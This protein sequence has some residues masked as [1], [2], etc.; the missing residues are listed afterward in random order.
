VASDALDAGLVVNAVT[1]SA[2]RL[3]PPLLVSDAEIDEAAA[4][5]RGVLS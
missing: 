5:L 2:L 3:A 1:R 4:I